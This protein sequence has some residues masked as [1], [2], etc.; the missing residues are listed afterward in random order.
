[1]A[2]LKAAAGGGRLNV[3]LS[4]MLL[5]HQEGHKSKAQYA[6]VEMDNMFHFLIAVHVFFICV[7]YK[8]LCSGLARLPVGK[9]NASQEIASHV[10]QLHSHGSDSH[11]FISHSKNICCACIGVCKHKGLFPR[12]LGSKF[13][14]HLNAC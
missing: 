3:V 6:W 10:W 4:S 5:S 9:Q 11:I 13:V 12:E 7:Q 8:V 14:L 1:M 2:P